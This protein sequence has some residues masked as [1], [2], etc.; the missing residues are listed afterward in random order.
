MRIKCSETIAGWL[1][2]PVHAITDYLHH[3]VPIVR[4]KHSRKIVDLVIG[5]TIMYA[6]ASF[7]HAYGENIICDTLGYA[8]HGI[9]LAPL[10][11]IIEAYWFEE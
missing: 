4:F 1:S 3:H 11:K 7:A 2:R 6:G 5:M 10:L 8:V 9:G